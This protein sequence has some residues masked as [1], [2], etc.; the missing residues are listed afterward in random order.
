MRKALRLFLNECPCDRPLLF[1]YSRHYLH[2][3]SHKITL[4]CLLSNYT[5][6]KNKPKQ[7]RASEQKLQLL[8]GKMSDENSDT[9]FTLSPEVRVC[10]GV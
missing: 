4:C 1:F 10:V 3:R 5:D 6:T 9:D 7:F 8:E 2:H